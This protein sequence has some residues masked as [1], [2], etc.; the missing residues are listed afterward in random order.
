MLISLWTDKPAYGL[1]DDVQITGRLNQVW[2]GTLNLEIIQTKQLSITTSSSDGGSGFKIQDGLI[3]LG[4]GSFAYTF[5]IPDDSIRLGNYKIRISEDIGSV[6]AVIHVVSN[7]DTFVVSDEP[8]TITSDKEI[9]ELGDKM[10]ISGFIKDPFS[11]SSYGTGSA[12]N[13]SISHEDGSALE[14]IGLPKEAKTREN[15]GVIVAF[16]FTAI[17]E[18]SGSYSVQIDVAKLLFADGN[19][20][21]TAQYLDNMVTKTFTVIDPLDLKDGA[22]ISLDKEVY[23]L[24]ETVYLTGL[25][26][27]TGNN[28]IDIS[29]TT[30]DG[31]ITNSGTPVEDQRFSWSWA[32]PI[33]ENRQ[34]IK[35]DDGRD[36][37]KSNLGIYK[38]K[39]ATDT[40]S[41]NLFFK[42]SIRP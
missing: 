32:T 15:S 1:G 34:N 16:D 3:V 6:T 21:A 26:P 28:S 12:V 17:P 13:I 42:V 2:I 4:D 29:L 11:N 37:T 36:V 20:V 19:Y 14:I 24:G 39:V 27:P 35:T 5:T 41:K 38:I 18:T 33:T 9:Y 10:I 25:I 31:A 40:Y 30:P 8:L 23:G 7:P 22:V